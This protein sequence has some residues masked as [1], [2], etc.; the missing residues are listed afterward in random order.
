MSIQLLNFD[1]SLPDDEDRSANTAKTL[2]FLTTADAN[3]I[4]PMNRIFGD[5]AARLL[6]DEE[7]INEIARFLNAN[8]ALQT[9]VNSGYAL[10]DGSHA[11]TEPQGGV[12]PVAGA[13][14]TTKTYVDAAVAALAE[15]VTDNT[16]DI[17]T[18][19]ASV[20]LFKKSNWTLHTWSG[21]TKEHLDLTLT[22]AIVDLNKVVS[23]Q[24][25]ERLNLGGGVCV[26]RQLMHGTV[27]DGFRVDDAW[28]LSTT[29]VRLLI[30]NTSNY[31][32]GYPA[33]TDY[34]LAEYTERHLRAV[35]IATQ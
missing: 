14:L 25:L 7:K 15:D 21:G 8:P 20:P 32:T 16:D 29:V 31:P 18:L 22:S 1:D 2:R 13:D 10:T 3:S 33:A 35:V 6:S 12:A 23:I 26:Y 27:G 19:G 17:T 34:D 9:F 11:F 28:I 30:P 24:V 5:L 4:L